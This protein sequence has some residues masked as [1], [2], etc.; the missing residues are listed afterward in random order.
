MRSI[1]NFL[2][3]FIGLI[4]FQVSGI[5]QTNS[6]NT[7]TNAA[8]V[9]YKKSPF[10]QKLWGKNYR[11]EWT[12]PV[13]LPLLDLSSALGGMKSYEEGGSHQSKSLHVT[14]AGD[15]EYALRSVDKSLSPV[16]P[17][18]F[19]QT[20]V[21]DI[22][23]DAISMS[24]PYGA[25]AVPLMAQA[26][27]IPHTYPQYFYLPQQT[28]LDTLN[29]RYAG[30]IY[31]L[32]Q[33]PK[34]D[35]SS[36]V[37]LGGFN[38]FI[39]SD[40]LLDDMFENNK[41]QVNQT[42]FTRARLFDMFIGDWDRHWDQWKWGAVD[43]A[44]QTFYIPVPTDRDQAFS[45][46]NG[47]LLSTGISA[48]GMKYL[49]SFGN[50]I[51]D[52]K[53]LSSEKRM[54]DRFLTNHV[55]LQQWQTQAQSLQ[56][57]LTDEVIEASVK[58]MP[59]EIFSI[60]GN[61]I[62]AKLKSRRS[63]LVDYATEY[64]KFLARE[65]EVVG[66]KESEIFEV[67]RLSD[68]ETSVNIFRI[69]KD[70]ESKA[71]PFYSRVF[72]NDETKEIRLF[73]L[74]GNDVYHINGNANSG[75]KIRII[76]G[77]QSDSVINNSNKKINV[78][79]DAINNYL[80]SNTRLHLV[81]STEHNYNYDTYVAD[82]KGL[83]P[84]VG[85]T[86]E[87]PFYV[88]LGY[89]ITHHKWRKKP[90]AYK[91]DIGVKFSITQKAFSVFYQGIF[92][93]L[94]GK[95][96]LLLNA[97][98]DLIRWI[99]FYGVGNETHYITDTKNVKFNRTQSKE[100]TGSIGLQREFGKSTIGISGFYQG[101]QIIN[102]TGRFIAKVIAPLNPAI[103]NTNNYAGASLNYRFVSIN[104][105]IVPTAGFTF[106]A[107]ASHF[108]NL[109]QTSETFQ[110]FSGIAQIYI[111]LFS[112]FSLSIR[113]NGGTVTGSN[114]IFYQLPHIG[115]ADDLRGYR[116]ERF[117]GRTAFAN[118]NELRYITKVKSYLMN[119]KF[120]VS[121]FYDEGRVWQP[122]E[123]SNTWHTDYGAGILIAPFN[124]LLANIAYG[125][126]KEKKMV[127]LRLIK[128]F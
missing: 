58:Q 70:G 102:D 69:K 13:T 122:G 5:A 93:E 27:G 68:N 83:R 61:D 38:K 46:H 109:T 75:I 44:K 106:F 17:K 72:K 21:E 74:S 57:A 28:A 78:Y 31:L 71:E 126:S 119:G 52:V 103:Y 6:I 77:D 8:G 39:G 84:I 49:Q 95:W 32:E 4:V 42:A 100:L 65:V 54:L 97:D 89:G 20:F 79:D 53:G 85:Y 60:S 15:K 35:W 127:Q 81:D 121:V 30:H 10:Y 101:V 128:S 25:L 91:Q 104:D 94:I 64:Y 117:F 73:G 55:T 34:G 125:I 1:Y 86:N 111:P 14:F 123:T 47:L 18:I 87:D 105:S 108:Q 112:K 120:G 92:P 98:Y 12:T 37:N 24:H 23:N 11:K 3:A 51:E 2:F 45:K 67:N 118:S 115:G 16:I 43:S 26:A 41:N 80:S 9:E 62:I 124:K 99:N 22:A 110:R 63:H 113:G 50:T 48:A 88:G 82:K 90:F 66:S 59:P 29:K 56:Q 96:D 19:K 107:N 76:G 33:R 36:A 116:R 40:K 7:Q 114:P